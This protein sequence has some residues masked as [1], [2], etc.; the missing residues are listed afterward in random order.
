MA[1]RQLRE[2]APHVGLRCSELGRVKAVITAIRIR[3]RLDI[4]INKY[5]AFLFASENTFHRNVGFRRVTNAPP[6]SK[7]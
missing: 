3:G 6:I 2:H 1:S 4:I 5:P 7:L